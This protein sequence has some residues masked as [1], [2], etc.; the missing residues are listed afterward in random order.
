MK[1]L[2]ESGDI[3]AQ[4]YEQAVSGLS[5]AKLQYDSAKLNYDTQSE[6]TVVTAPIA[7]VLARKFLMVLVVALI[8]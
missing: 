4:A 2:Y 1:A 5:M 7:G 8:F 6:N 3:S